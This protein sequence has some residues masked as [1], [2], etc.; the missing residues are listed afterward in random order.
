LVAW[1]ALRLGQRGTTLTIFAATAITIWDW[2][3]GLGIAT[4]KG[5]LES[6][7]EL[8]SFLCVLAVT[9]MALVTITSERQK[10]E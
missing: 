1:A 4:T 8:Q 6:L 2:S 7:L 3:N 5:D 10:A 9:G